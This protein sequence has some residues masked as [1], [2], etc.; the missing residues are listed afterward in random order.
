M[1]WWTQHV[2]SRPERVSELNELGFVWE[3][4]QPEWNLV[5]EGIITYY[6][7]HGHIKIPSAYIVPFHDDTWP[8]ATWGIPL[9]NCVHRIRTRHDFLRDEETSYSRRKQLDGLGFVWD[10]SENAFHTFVEALKVY[11]KLEEN[12]NPKKSQIGQA[13]RVPSTFTV[14]S[15]TEYGWPQSLW[16]YPL[17]VKCTAVRQKQL[18]LKNNPERARILEDIGFNWCGNSTLGWLQV[19]HAA[20]IYS[21]LHGKTLD[22]PAKFIV[23]SPPETNQDSTSLSMG[24]AWPWPGK[25]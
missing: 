22:V 25:L 11:Q 8:K 1:N 10:V 23:P 18:Y 12:N 14:P 3:R 15:G 24:E 13:L 9:G 21:K 19:V 2:K 16:G 17:G 5:L 6:S 20:A 7:I 4:L